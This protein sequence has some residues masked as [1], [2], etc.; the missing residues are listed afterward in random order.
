MFYNSVEFHF[1][2]NSALSSWQKIDPSFI[3]LLTDFFRVKRIVEVYVNSVHR[4][5][6]PNES[7]YHGIGQA[8]DIHSIKYSDGELL[9][10]YSAGE[11]YSVSQDDF[12]F[13][14]FSSWFVNYKIEYISPAN[15]LTGYEEHNNIYRNYSKEQKKAVLA[16]IG[17]QNYSYEINR[18]H[19][20]H[21]HLAINPNSFKSKSS[22]SVLIFGFAAALAALLNVLNK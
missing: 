9:S 16:K 7:S 14:E 19:L 8:I 1:T 11:D 4:E 20:D 22:K 6:K 18:N 17:T 12:L 2:S 3:K 10:F 13:R 15:I 21:L 5:N